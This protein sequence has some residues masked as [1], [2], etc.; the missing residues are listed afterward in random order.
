M[1]PGA[2]SQVAAPG[3][4]RSLERA[5]HG[6]SDRDHPPAT[7]AGPG[8][9]PD[10]GCGNLVPLG[11]W[12]RCIEGRVAGGGQPGG[13]G[14]RGEVHPACA[15]PREQLQPQRSARRRHLG[16]PGSGGV[17]CLHA[18]ERKRQW[19]VG[20]LDR[21]GRGGRARTRTAR[22]A[23]RSGSAAAGSR[24][25]RAPPRGRG[26]P[27]RGGGCLRARAREAADGTRW[28]S[29]SHRRRRP[30]RARCRRSP[31]LPAGAR[32]ARRA[33]FRGGK[34]GGWPRRSPPGGPLDGTARAARRCA[35]PRPSPARGSTWRSRPGASTTG[36]AASRTACFSRL[37]QQRQHPGRGLLG[38]GQGGG[39]RLGHRL[40]VHPGI[41]LPG[42]DGQEAAPRRRRAPRPRCAPAARAP[43]S[44]RHRRPSRRTAWS[45]R[46]S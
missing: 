27:G 14:Q 12:Q 3:A 39:I 9:R 7:P 13:V 6:G 42:V 34:R 31:P 21:I 19:L 11:E 35:C 37:P 33:R 25:P 38:P 32:R 28:A 17:R 18:G 8:H 41:H 2:G 16:G 29:A 5:D 40:T 36:A 45:P 22:R 15:D 23:S 46:P 43:P 20:V 44:T 10:G 26:V 30:R 4:G 24:D 1:R